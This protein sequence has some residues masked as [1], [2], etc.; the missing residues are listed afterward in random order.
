MV[1]IVIPPIFRE[2][3]KLGAAEHVAKRV[4][5]NARCWWWNSNGD[6]K[7]VLTITYFDK[8]GVPRLS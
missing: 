5:Q 6:I 3:T 7:R 4:A 2:L 1:R 8:L